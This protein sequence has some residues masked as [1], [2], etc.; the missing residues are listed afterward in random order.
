MP[1][2]RRN[3][4]PNPADEGRPR[5]HIVEIS[6]SA[7]RA[8]NIPSSIAELLE[9]LLAK[10]G[11]IP[12]PYEHSSFVLVH[13]PYLQPFADVNKRTSRLAANLPLIKNYLCP[14]TFLGVPVEAY[15]RAMLG[16]YEL[17]RTELLHSGCGPDWRCGS[18]VAHPKQGR[19]AG[20]R[21]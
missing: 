15:N 4:L 20:S 8:L 10:A 5:Q 18:A 21:A 1:R 16:V 11:E 13:L 9:L 19:G 14:L 12:D 17:T 3:L 6:G 7:Y 2:S